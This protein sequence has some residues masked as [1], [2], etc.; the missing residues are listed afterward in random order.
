MK[1]LL[2]TEDEKN[3]ILGL[4]KNHILSEQ[5]SADINIDRT[6]RAQ[7]KTPL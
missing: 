1:N 6:N 7:I 4:H 2:I 3:R 5:G